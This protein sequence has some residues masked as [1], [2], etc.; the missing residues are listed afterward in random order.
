M[1]CVKRCHN[2]IFYAFSKHHIALK[3]EKKLQWCLDVHC[4]ALLFSNISF[5]VTVSLHDILIM[6][7][8]FWFYLM[9]GVGILIL[10]GRIFS[11]FSFIWWSQWT[12]C[13]VLF[14]CFQFHF[15]TYCVNIFSSF[16]HIHLTAL[17]YLK[18]RVDK[19]YVDIVVKVINCNFKKIIFTK[20]KKI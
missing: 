14:F 13:F 3:D 2:I 15:K 6:K 18:R 11:F 12:L 19:T 16:V 1:K 4:T 17:Q 20:P 9:S 10:S 5:C 7:L 8:T